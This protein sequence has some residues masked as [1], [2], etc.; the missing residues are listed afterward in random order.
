MVLSD[1]VVHAAAEFGVPLRSGDSLANVS[2]ETL[3]KDDGLR[4]LFFAIHR[5]Q[6]GSL[7]DPAQ[8]TGETAF[9]DAALL[10][11]A[12]ERKWVAGIQMVVAEDKVERAVV[13][14]GARLGD[15]LDAAAAWSGILRG[16]GVLVELD[17]LNGGSGDAGAA[18]LHAI[19]YQGD[20]IRPD[21]TCIQKTGHRTKEVLVENRQ[22]IQGG[23]VHRD[24]IE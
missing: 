4:I 10:W 16:V 7:F 22:V 13:F 15:D 18:G 11:R 20:A 24:G 12:D 21:G 1:L 14:R 23:T 2:R 8:R 19:H 3:R 17:L 9:I 6:E 5:D